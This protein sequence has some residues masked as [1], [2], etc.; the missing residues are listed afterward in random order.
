MSPYFTPEILVAVNTW[1]DK[2][3]GFTA[4][5]SDESLE[6]LAEH[7]LG[8]KM[9]RTR[10]LQYLVH[11]FWKAEYVS[12]TRCAEGAFMH[13]APSLTFA[14]FQEA[15]AIY[16]EVQCDRVGPRCDELPEAERHA[17]I[18]QCRFF[19]DWRNPEQVARSEH[20]DRDA[21]PAVLP[22]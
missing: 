9:M 12:F 11:G 10:D 6:Y 18:G 20:V 22:D 1:S 8:E 14:Q 4:K 3:Y 7:P 2:F 13:R 5:E 16:S 19:P 17:K 21:V 15:K